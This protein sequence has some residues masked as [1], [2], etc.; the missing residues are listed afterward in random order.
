M[1][2]VQV[3]SAFERVWHWLQALTIILLLVTGLEIHAPDSVHLLGFSRA[4]WVHEA[5][6]LFT[7]ANAF[8][9]LFYHLA[10]GAIRQFFPQ[11]RD[12]FSLAIAQVAYYTRGI[13]S[14]E[15]HP[16]EH[17]PGQKLNVLQQVTYLGVLNLVLPLQIATGILMWK[18]QDWAAFVD[19]VGGLHVVASVHVL[20]AWAFGAFV[21]MHVYLTTTGRTP[22]A[23]MRA[24]VLGWE[25]APEP[26]SNASQAATVSAPVVSEVGHEAK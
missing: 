11:P 22:L 15:P 6:A 25:E 13:F 20:C 2:R 14:G 17:G 24:M 12:F 3:Y 7:I 18:A 4:T 8:L 1:R 9:S 23:H 10:T 26:M 19:R 5:L 21:V 16:F